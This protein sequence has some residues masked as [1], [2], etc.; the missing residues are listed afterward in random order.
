MLVLTA[1]RSLNV[2]F[3][4]KPTAQHV[5]CL[6][7]T[8]WQSSTLCSLCLILAFSALTVLPMYPSNSAAIEPWLHPL[9][10]TIICMI[11]TVAVCLS[12]GPYLGVLPAA[13]LL[14]T[15]KFK[16]FLDPHPSRIASYSLHRSQ[17][18]H[19]HFTR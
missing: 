18:R 7:T 15:Q 6:I 17:R 19:F 12:T 10:L 9:R 13:P 3:C 1:T 16:S 8:L 4:R 11:L 2:T 5:S 14:T